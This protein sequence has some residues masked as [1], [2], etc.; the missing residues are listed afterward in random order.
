MGEGRKD[1]GNQGLPK[2]RLTYINPPK[3]SSR[4][5]EKHVGFSTKQEEM[6][7]KDAKRKTKEA[8]L[9]SGGK[10]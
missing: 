2:K 9:A 8:G 1:T 6:G 7:G 10:G 4:K 3:K 5:Q